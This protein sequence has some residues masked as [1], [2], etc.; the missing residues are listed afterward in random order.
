[1][2][3]IALIL[4]VLSPF[5]LRA[6]SYD[7]CLVHYTLGDYKSALTFYEADPSLKATLYDSIKLLDAV[8]TSYINVGQ[9]NTAKEILRRC[10]RHQINTAQTSSLQYAVVMNNL[11]LVHD[12]QMDFDSSLY[13][14]NEAIKIRKRKLPVDDLAIA[15]SYFNL[16]SLFFKAGDYDKAEELLTLALAIESKHYTANDPSLAMTFNNLGTVNEEC[17]RYEEA[18][19]NYSKAAAIF[20][21]RPGKKSFSYGLLQY[22]Q[23]VCYAKLNQ[24]DSAAIY[25]DRA[26]QVMTEAKVTLPEYAQM[27]IRLI[28]RMIA[29]RGMQ[30]AWSEIKRMELLVE[31]N[32]AWKSRKPDLL[33]MKARAFAVEKNYQEAIRFAE[34]AYKEFAKCCNEENSDYFAI[35]DFRASLEFHRKNLESFHRSFAEIHKAQLNHIGSFFPSFSE[36]EREQYFFLVR[37]YF[38][39]YLT[40]LLN[41]KISGAAGQA[42][43]NQLATKA[44]LLNYANRWRQQIL[45][46]GDLE[47]VK[48]FTTWQ[49]LKSQIEVE[50][51]K[52]VSKQQI[53]IDSL[54]ERANALEKKLSARSE[55]F[56]RHVDRQQATWQQVR[57][58]L[59][60][61]EAAVEIIRFRKFDYDS[62]FEFTNDVRYAALIVTPSSKHDP[63]VVF[64]PKGSDLENR[65]IRYYRN[66]VLYK[67]DDKESYEIFWKPLS[68]K[69]K[70]V[71]RVFISSDGIFNLINFNTLRNPSTGKYLLEEIELRQL[72]NTRDLLTATD[73]EAYNNY[74]LLF[75]SPNYDRN[76]TN[77]A[78]LTKSTEESFG[79]FYSLRLERGAGLAYLPGARKEI[80]SL[81]DLLESRN[82]KVDAYLGEDALEGILKHSLKPNI[83]HIATHGYFEKD[84]T[85]DPNQRGLDNPLLR[86]GLMMAGASLALE[87]NIDTDDFS[88][89]DDGV[90]TS[91]EAMELNLENTELVVLSACETGLGEIKNGEGVYGLQRAFR[92]AGARNLVMSLWRVDDEVTMVLM[93]EFY[94]NYLDSGDK[95]AALKKA[96]LTI[97]EKFPQPVYWGAFILVGN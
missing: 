93:K 15:E 53:P 12:E 45:R 6:Q 75:G 51:K 90:L 46:S 22:N 83:L 1:M 77:T 91:Y 29:K 76:K 52:P 73:K 23:A 9:S 42:Y 27:K 61:K 7:S 78:L 47:L 3:R 25:F 50:A 21:V 44:I 87:S 56:A 85:Y 68:A 97:K 4:S 38:E 88:L 92:V 16:G 11:G 35:S 20:A 33:I 5:F 19:A 94:V 36:K 26:D 63:D 57:N 28:G 39:K 49:D 8:S 89:R 74:A 69:L 72:T 70:G 31:K 30:V 65:A 24:L 86:S 80:E 41:N 71:K 84:V 54:K 59:K 43:N 58:K 34:D 18:M 62:A 17:G 64:F 81:R 32:D 67:Q 2:K 95:Y 96:Q 48:Y 66:A 14:L 60:K 55:L 13:Y 37:S 82:W 79:S 40:I 10:R